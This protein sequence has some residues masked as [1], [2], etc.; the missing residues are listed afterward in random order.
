MG[1]SMG[2]EQHWLHTNPGCTQDS[3]ERNEEPFEIN[4]PYGS[5][6]RVY[7]FSDGF[8]DQFGGPKNKKFLIR[9]L[10]EK[11]LE[12]AKT[13]LNEQEKNFRDTFAEWKGK[14][15]QIDDIL[16]MAIEL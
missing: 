3:C 11:I 13:P 15:E 5:G 6:D 12:L 14:N 4:I 1:L 7:M 10:Q 8:I 9:R 16:I 2:D